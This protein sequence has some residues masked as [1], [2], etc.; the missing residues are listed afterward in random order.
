MR[1]A[2]IDIRQKLKEAN[3]PLWRLAIK[4]GC[5]EVTLV[6]RLR[7]ELSDKDKISIR[8]QI[9]EIISEDMEV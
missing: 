3:I 6:R 2:N 4:Q 7:M 8:N 9:K 5:S 1:K